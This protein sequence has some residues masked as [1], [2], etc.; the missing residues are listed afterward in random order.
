MGALPGTSVHVAIAGPPDCSIHFNV[1]FSN[2][3]Q[4]WF[5][6]ASGTFVKALGVPRKE[7]KEPIY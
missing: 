7:G 6:H 2:T 5:S 4:L 1:F 3:S